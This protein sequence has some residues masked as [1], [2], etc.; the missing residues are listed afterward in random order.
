MTLYERQPLSVVMKW[1][2]ELGTGKRDD[3]LGN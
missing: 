1:I 2:D 3:V